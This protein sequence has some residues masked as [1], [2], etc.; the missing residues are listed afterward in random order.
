M[1]STQTNSPAFRLRKLLESPGVLTIPGCY[2]AFSALLIERGGFP[3]AYMS[4]FGSSASVLGEPDTGIMDF[5]LMSNHAGNIAGAISIP[6]L[7]DGDTGYGNAVNTYRTV[8]T[9]ASRGVA[10]IQLEDQVTPKRCGHTQGK[11]IVPLPEMLGKIRA[12]LDAAAE[13]DIV[14]IARTDARAM[15]GFQSALERCLAF[16]EAGADIIFMEAPKSFEEMKTVAQK[17]KKPLLANMVEGGET[18]FL[19]STKLQE[20]GYKIGLYPVTLLLSVTRT[21]QNQLAKL[22]NNELSSMVREQIPFTELKY[23]V[24]FPEYDDLVEKYGRVP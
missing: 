4:G 3:A 1:N 23:L 24:G 7:A 22:G 13:Q 16:E 14:I 2:D 15:E 18:P 8:K 11:T 20:L 19:N 21:I 12:A 9:Y 5:T 17:I 10:A 6:L